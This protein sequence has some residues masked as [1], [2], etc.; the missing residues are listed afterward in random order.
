MEERKGEKGKEGAGTRTTPN[1]KAAFLMVTG[2]NF[3]RVRGLVFVIF[4][5]ENAATLKPG[6]GSVKVIENVAIR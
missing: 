3:V 1:K 5:F 6:Y 4:D 2:V